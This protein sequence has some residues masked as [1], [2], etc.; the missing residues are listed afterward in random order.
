MI[1]HPLRD[2]AAYRP[3]GRVP[4]PNGAIGREHMCAVMTCSRSHGLAT[5]METTTLQ[6]IRRQVMQ[7]CMKPD[8]DAVAQLAAAMRLKRDALDLSISKLG[9]LSGV[10]ASQVSRVLSGR[11]RTLSSNVV[12]ICKALE[13]DAEGDHRSQSSASE[14]D[15]PEQRLLRRLSDVW[16]KTPA[17]ADRLSTF[18][19]Q[20][21]VLRRTAGVG[22]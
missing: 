10:D 14:P 16:D 13:L 22:R 4:V 19:E 12:Q 3:Q 17:D 7:I 20:L 18:L 5:P 21:A 8:R 15:G 9:L 11:F 1:D 2:K 6:F